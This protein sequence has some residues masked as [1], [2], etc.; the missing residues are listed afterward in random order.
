MGGPTT[1]CSK[2]S[3][4]TSKVQ[5]KWSSGTIDSIAKMGARDS[6]N[7]KSSWVNNGA[8]LE[9]ISTW[10]YESFA[11]AYKNSFSTIFNTKCYAKKNC[12]IDLSQYSWP[13]T[14][15]TTSA[16]FFKVYCKSDTILSTS[17]KNIGFIVIAF[18]ILC[19]L[20]IWIALEVH[21]TYE[22]LE[23]LEINDAVLDGSD[24]TVQIANVP[25]HEDVRILK[26]QIC[27]Y[28]E[29]D[30]QSRLNEEQPQS[31]DMHLFKIAQCNLALT[32]YSIMSN[33]K[34]KMKY[35]KQFKILDVKESIL[36][37]STADS[38]TVQN[39]K[40]K[41][42][43]QR[44]K[45]KAKFDANEQVIAEL[46]NSTEVKAVRIYITMQNMSGKKQ[47]IEMLQSRKRRRCWGLIKSNDL[48]FQNKQ[49]QASE[50]PKASTIIWE[51]LPVSKKERWIRV[52]I[53]YLF[54]SA[55]ILISFAVMLITKNYQRELNDTYNVSSCSSTVTMDMALKDYL[56]P[57][58]ERN[59]FM[60]CYCLQQ[61]NDMG[62][63]V[64]DIVFTDNG[65]YCSSWYTDYMSTLAL[66]YILAFTMQ[67][68]N[69]IVKTILRLA[70]KLE[71]RVNKA[72]EVISNIFK[73]SLTQIINTAILLLVV[74]MKVSFL[75]SWFPVFAGGYND[76]TTSWYSDVGATIMI[77]MLFSIVTPH[78]ANFF[79]HF[80]RFVRRWFDRKWTWNKRQTRKLFQIDYESLYLG[81]EYLIEFRYSN[82]IAMVYLTLLF[83]AGMPILYFFAACIFFVVYWVDKV[84]LFKIYRQ[85]P[86]LGIEVIRFVRNLL[87]PGIVL[88]FGFTFWMFSNS[89]IFGSYSQNM[90]SLG[91]QTIDSIA[92]EDYSW[93]RVDH[94]I[95][96]Y[97]TFIYAIAFGSF[98]V[99]FVLRNAIKACFTNLWCKRI[100]KQNQIH[101]S[102]FS[103]DYCIR[104]C[105][106][107]LN[108]RHFTK[109]GGTRQRWFSFN[110][111]FIL[112]N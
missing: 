48:S 19:I 49:I 20:F 85:P 25:A 4:L 53:V 45:L 96:Q 44:I 98:I 107:P 13:S 52:L 14:C 111:K 109:V 61:Y 7:S 46:R 55:L 82:M 110:L 1:S 95:N 104:R 108:N 83:G 112:K 60:F 10:D 47:L 15:N 40:L 18:D 56:N 74:N 76:F 67:I 72:D 65:T 88:H 29:V 36:K 28:I 58:G 11:T 41:L 22:Q 42:E 32:K 63:S 71:K 6:K 69:V 106:V 70:S 59:G 50:A 103:E 26:A 84:T 31:Q 39:E 102:D 62:T 99:A 89:L 92:N 23:D 73:M 21:D 24:F 105:L 37:N 17:R 90:L 68:I 2:A 87:M 12:Q 51:N 101:D 66:V 91:A 77:M 75:P 78:I 79:L 97:H 35:N 27:K 30:L 93:L 3:T 9:V 16:G 8:S 34:T 54:S 38:N 43:R 5:V 86:R 81:P 64:K 80:V 33:F 94:K 57:K 100:L